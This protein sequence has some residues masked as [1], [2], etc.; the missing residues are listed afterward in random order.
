MLRVTLWKNIIVL[1]LARKLPAKKNKINKYKKD[2]SNKPSNQNGPQFTSYTD[3]NWSL[4]GTIDPS[5]DT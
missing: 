4:Y 5:L 2:A 3:I 1:Y